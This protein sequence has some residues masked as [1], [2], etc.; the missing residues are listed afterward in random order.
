[1]IIRKPYA[2]LIKNFRKIH[3]ALL[4]IG[5]FVFYKTIDTANFVNAFM[6]EG[7][8]DLYADPVT[9]HITTLMTVGLFILI[10]G[11][12]ALLFLLLHKK[13]PWKTYLIPV[14]TYVLLFF[15]LSMIKGFFGSY[16]E[17]IDAADL[18]LARDLLMIFLV[19]QLPALAIFVIRIFGLDVKKFDFNADLEFLDL[20]EEDREEIE[21]SLDF[22]IHALKRVCRRLLR[23]LG[24][25]YREHKII[26]WILIVFVSVFVLYNTYTFLFV[27][28]KSYKQGQLYRANG[29]SFQITNSYFTDKDYTGNII[30]KES[31]FVVIEVKVKNNEEP[32]KFD[33]GNFHLKAGSKDYVTSET[34]YAKEFEDLG[35]SYSRVKEL[36]RDEEITFLIIYK[37]D[38]KFKKGR[39]V[40]YYQEENGIYKLRKIKLKI[41]DLTEME[42]TKKLEFGEFFDVEIYKKE[43]TITIEDVEFSDE[44]TYKMNRCTSNHCEIVE[45]NYQAPK[46]KKVLAITFASDAYESKNVIDFLKKYGRISYK[47]SKGKTKA[48]DIKAAVNKTYLGKVVYLVVPKK[49][50]TYKNVEL[51]FT[52]RNKSYSYSLT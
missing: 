1:M 36:K 14:A 4:L 12:I 7:T 37:V 45:E 47:D 18:R 11:S 20:S 39:F 16:T 26:S 25:L 48:V 33:T 28:H 24:Y 40:L 8:Y 38:K 52:I 51:L 21:V 35:A 29:Y 6:K 13:K 50:D 30:S 15:V 32:R 2:F 17:S 31:N 3:I 42:E 23:N 9:R 49:L 43:D 27:T 22:D 10:V 46:D 19:A 41:K 34:T 44:L 5:L